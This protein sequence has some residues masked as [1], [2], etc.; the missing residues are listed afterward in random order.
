MNKDKSKNN[1]LKQV[2]IIQK[3]IRG[4][5]TRKYFLIPPGNY[6]TKNWRKNRKWYHNKG[7][8]SECEKYQISLI[9]KITTRVLNKTDDRINREINEIISSQKP[10]INVDGFEWTE[11]FDG[12]IIKNNNTFYFN[13]KFVCHDGGA[14]KRTLDVVYSFIKAQIDY[15]IKHNTTNIYF[16][17]ILDGDYCFK[18]M[19]SIKYWINKEK[20][21]NIIKYFF[22]GSLYEFQK[23]KIKLQII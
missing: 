7:R 19:D 13:L 9:Q 21:E 12:K 18:K 15:L 8:S 5:L 20:H 2:I 6:Q 4:Y 17:N 23:N 22:I 11:N 14:Q 1:F 3:Y 10:F 16:I